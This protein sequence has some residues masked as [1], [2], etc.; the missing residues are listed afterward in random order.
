MAG[1]NILALL[2]PSA[3]CPELIITNC[4]SSSLTSGFLFSVVCRMCQK[5]KG[6][7]TVSVSKDLTVHAQLLPAAPTS[8]ELPLMRCLSCS[9]QS[10]HLPPAGTLARARVL[11]ARLLLTCPEWLRIVCWNPLFST[12]LLPMWLIMC[13]VFLIQLLSECWKP[14]KY[15]REVTVLPPRV[16]CL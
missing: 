15:V 1:N 7:V 16:R 5:G 9:L 4:L 3:L 11:S 13:K 10:C 8:S 2:T 12:S 6:Q 14:A